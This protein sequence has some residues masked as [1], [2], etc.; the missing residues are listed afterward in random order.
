[1]APMV[2]SGCLCSA[3]GLVDVVDI[4]VLEPRSVRKA[5]AGDS[6]WGYVANALSRW[7]IKEDDQPDPTGGRPS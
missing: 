2:E 4:T 7:P 5:K 6:L 3:R 1:M